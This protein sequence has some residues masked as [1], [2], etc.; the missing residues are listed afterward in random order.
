MNDAATNIKL[1]IEYDGTRYHGWQRQPNGIS[2]QEEIERAAGTILSQKISLIGSGRTDA[3]VHAVGQTANFHCRTHVAVP[4]LHKGLNSLLPDDIVIRECT[5]AP[6][7]FHARF[8]AKGKVYCYSILNRPLPAA[9]G[10]GYYWWIKEPLDLSAMQE[11]AVH[12]LGE[13]DFKSFEG[14][15]S[16]R[17]H[18]V[19]HVTSARWDS[20][21]SG[22]L[23]LTIEANGFL[24]YMV[25]NI[26]GTLVLVGRKKITTDQFNE[27][28]ASR[29][30]N[31]A[32]PT[33]PAQGL[34]LIAVKYD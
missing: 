11:A 26:V 12:I 3:G 34:C 28:M 17:A 32:G 5:P 14:T 1:V 27:I 13:N 6:P 4:D 7:D 22:S 21:P 10:R 24:R 20:D 31:R 23:C 33:A 8:D 18:T 16:P 30:R 15:G 19:R 2:I 9:I 29:D 25:R